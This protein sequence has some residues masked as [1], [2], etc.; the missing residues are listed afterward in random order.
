MIE[1][2]DRETPPKAPPA[3]S[4]LATR[5][6]RIVRTHPGEAK[7]LAALTAVLVASVLWHPADDGGFVLC[8]FRR[9]AGLPCMGCGL[10]RSFCALAKGEIGR[11]FAF[12]PLGP[13]LF[14]AACL[15]WVRGA[16]FF[17]GRRLGVARFDEAV[18]RWRVAAVALA[19]LCGVWVVQLAVLGVEGRLGELARQGLLY[20]IVW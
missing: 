19:L 16:T 3:A 9:L 7:L 4:G 20:Q 2:E 15:Y 8:A 12:H 5:V 18:R 14:A 6:A 11:A 10:T 13:A 17:A 1:T